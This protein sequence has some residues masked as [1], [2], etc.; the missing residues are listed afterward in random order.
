[1][2][3]EIKELIIRTNIVSDQKGRNKGAG[4]KLSAKEKQDIIDACTERVI[5][6]ID[7]KNER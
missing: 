7:R 1:M 3:V 2:P 4:N 6:L 5:R